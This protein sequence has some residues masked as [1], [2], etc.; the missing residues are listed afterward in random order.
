MPDV[1]QR[2]VKANAE[3]L[4]EAIRAEF[5]ASLFSP[6][7]CEAI[8]KSLGI[9]VLPLTQ[10]VELGAK[11]ESVHRLAAMS[12]CLSAMTVCAGTQRI[13][14]YNPANPAGRRANSVSRTLPNFRASRAPALGLGGCRRWDER[15]EAEADWQAGALLVA[16]P[17]ALCW[18]HNGGDLDGG[19]Q[20]FGASR[21]LFNWRVSQTGIVRHLNARQGFFSRKRTA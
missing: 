9:P 14:L 18:M 10:M 13:I 19:A 1:L 2:G 12:S 5:G 7:D 4:A 15:L 8:C 3:R 20:H 6:L 11:P 21:A 16:R 17:A